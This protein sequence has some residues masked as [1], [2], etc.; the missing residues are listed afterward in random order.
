MIKLNKINAGNSPY[1][2]ARK[3]NKNFSDLEKELLTI[4]NRLVPY[5]V[6][7]SVLGET[8]GTISATYDSE[9]VASG[10]MY[11]FYGLKKELELTAAPSVG[12]QVKQWIINNNFIPTTEEL[13]TVFTIE[14]LTADMFRYLSID[15]GF[16][17]D[18]YVEFEDVE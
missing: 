13:T 8:G 14:S 4:V 15:E 1:D 17:I 5:T 11:S 10:L 7:Y 3:L 2:K 16:E 6:N 12:K 9:A 18:I